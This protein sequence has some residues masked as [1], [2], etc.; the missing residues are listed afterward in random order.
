M[1]AFL[2][3]KITSFPF[4]FGLIGSNVLIINIV[5]SFILSIFSVLSAYLNLDPKYT[6]LIANGFCGSLTTMSSFALENIMMFEN[7]QFLQMIINA[8]S[9]RSLALLGTI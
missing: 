4:I 2:R 6:F 9:N 7:N 3:Y 5:G 8:V 1:G